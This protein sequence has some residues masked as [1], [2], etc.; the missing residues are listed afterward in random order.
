MTF[1]VAVDGCDFTATP[2]NNLNLVTIQ[3]LTVSGTD[4]AVASTN[5][6]SHGLTQSA[7]NIVAYYPD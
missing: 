3:I 5:I 7:F 4:V 1:P 6:A 2:L